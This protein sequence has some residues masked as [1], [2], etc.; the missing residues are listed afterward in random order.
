MVKCRVIGESDLFSAVGVHYVDLAKIGRT[1][2]TMPPGHEGDLAAVRG[3]SRRVIPVWIIGEVC[4]FAAVGIHHIDLAPAI[5]VGHK[6]DLA[7]VGSAVRLSC[8][9]CAL[10]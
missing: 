8:L 5:P 7:T 1:V 6:G 3:P 9:T 10:P 2:I 4:L